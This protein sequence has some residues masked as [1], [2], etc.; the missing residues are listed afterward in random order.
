MFDKDIELLKALIQ[1]PS[2]SGQEQEIGLLV[3]KEM[4]EAGL[5]TIQYDLSEK[6]PIILGIL[7]GQRPGPSI[8]FNGHTDTHSILDYKEDP[9]YAIEADGNI[10][11]RGSVDMKGGLAAMICAAR[12]LDSKKDM[13]SGKLIVAAVPDEE[14]KSEGTTFLA[15]MGIHADIGVVGEP[16]GLYIGRAMRGVTHID[17]RIEGVSRHTSSWNQEGNAIIQMGYAL[18]ALNKEL[19]ARYQEKKHELLGTPLYNIGLI[20]GGEKPNVVPREC[21][22]TMLRRDLPEENMEEVFR[23]IKEIVSMAI[24]EMCRVTVCESEMQKRSNNRRRMPMVVANDS[25]VVKELEKAAL[26]ILGTVPLSGVVPFWCDAS[27]MTNEANIPTVVFGPGDIGCAHSSKE[28]IEVKQYR[29]AIDIYE[30]MAWNYL[31][32]VEV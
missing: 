3:K 23:E 15:D 6:R 8:L 22:V 29:R 24:S 27:I 7:E 25:P 19:F 21:I 17:I 28:W 1:T 9:F 26:E 14:L 10:Y 30:R 4:E 13:L 32:A 11:G 16:T 18:A 12:R 5:K 20:R 2:V 31:R